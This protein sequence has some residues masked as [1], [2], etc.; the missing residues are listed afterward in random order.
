MNRVAIAFSTRDRVEL[1]KRTVEPLLQPDKFDTFWFDGSDTEEGQAFPLAEGNP[2]KEIRHNIRGGADATIV[3]A[4][5]NMLSKKELQN[6]YA[7]PREG[8]YAY[9]AEV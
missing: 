4:L 9:V 3:Y 2:V 1:S 7:Y 8:G 6:Y 5:T